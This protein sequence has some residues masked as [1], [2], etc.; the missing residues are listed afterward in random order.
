[1]AISD[2]ESFLT[3]VRESLFEPSDLARKTSARLPDLRPPPG[4]NKQNRP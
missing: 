3:Q 1:M 2:S 4:I